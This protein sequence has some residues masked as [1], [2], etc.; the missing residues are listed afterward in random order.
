MPQSN[1]SFPLSSV[2]LTSSSGGGPHCVPRA[3]TQ[4]QR[5]LVYSSSYSAHVAILR[6]LLSVHPHYWALCRLLALS[7]SCGFPLLTQL[8]LSCLKAFSRGKG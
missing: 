1:L 6:A 8:L 2:C 7:A 4:D 5:P 3:E